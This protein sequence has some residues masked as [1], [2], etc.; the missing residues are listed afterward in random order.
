VLART[1]LREESVEGI[2]SASNG[3]VRG[4]LAVWLD[5]V[6]KAEQFPAGVADL[7]ARLSNVNTYD[8]SHG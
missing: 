3:L 1:G 4:H 7:D 5:A 8:F 6:F 2:I